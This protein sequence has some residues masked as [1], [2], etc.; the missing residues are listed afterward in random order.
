MEKSCKQSPRGSYW[1]M[2]LQNHCR[3]L[4]IA[5]PSHCGKRTKGL[6]PEEASANYSLALAGI[7]C[8]DLKLLKDFG[9]D[10]MFVSAVL[11]LLDEGHREG[12]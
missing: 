2:L 7:S 8:K 9:H 1:K 11:S 5:S 3:D 10:F 4:V 12:R 6:L